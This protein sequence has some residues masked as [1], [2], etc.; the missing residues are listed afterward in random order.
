MDFLQDSRT[1]AL[2]D[3]DHDGRVEV[4]LKNRNGP[5]LRFLK[6][7]MPQ[8]APAI[9]FRLQ[10]KKSNRDAIGAVVTIETSVG[11]QAKFV[12]A[13]SGFLTQHSKEVFFGLGEA[14]GPVKATIRWPSGLEH[15]L[16][17]LPANHR[18]WIEEGSA[19]VR[20]A[21]FALPAN[22]VAATSRRSPHHPV[23]L[24]AEL[25]TWL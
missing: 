17:D 10:G 21:A 9:A 7:V 12:Q 25:G 23:Q 20:T 2:A 13:G 8:L 18:I 11:R 4:A 5:Q 1:F 15:T 6:N 22:S 16:G 19:A 24:P 3:F 14:K